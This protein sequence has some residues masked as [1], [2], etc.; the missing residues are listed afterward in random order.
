MAIQ[1]RWPSDRGRSLREKEALLA[2][3][4]GPDLL[5]VLQALTFT[6]EREGIS[7]RV[8]LT[9]D[10]TVGI[11]IGVAG[12]QHQMMVTSD[13]Q[14]SHVTYIGAQKAQRMRAQEARKVRT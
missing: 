7:Y 3:L 13:E 8:N 14:E 5:Q 9:T 2:I 4:K 10:C 11:N 12:A 6:A 1:S